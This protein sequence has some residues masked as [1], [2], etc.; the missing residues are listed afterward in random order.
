MTNMNSWPSR[1]IGVRVI[2]QLTDRELDQLADDLRGDKGDWFETIRPPKSTGPHEDM[3]PDYDHEAA[4]SAAP[5]EPVEEYRQQA[6][7]YVEAVL[8]AREKIRP[9][10]LRQ[11]SELPAGID[12]HT[13]G[14]WV[15]YKATDDRGPVENDRPASLAR[16]TDRG[17]YQFFTPGESSVLEEIVIEQFQERPFSLAKLPTIPNREPDAVLILYYLDD[18]YR[19]DLRE[20]YQNEPEEDTYSLASPYDSDAPIVKPR[21]FK[22]NKETRRGEYSEKFERTRES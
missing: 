8:A 19:M 5:S 21:G 20:R 4:L 13:S 17:K 7:E 6:I 9:N 22:T 1:P 16:T 14:G 15:W 11:L 3:E 10:S 12:R 2:D 18:R